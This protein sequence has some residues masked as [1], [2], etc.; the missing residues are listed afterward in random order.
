MHHAQSPT[1]RFEAALRVQV[2]RDA[3]GT[4]DEGV[5]AMVR[6]IDAVEAV[7]AIELR[8]MV[9]RLNDV[10]VDATVD[11][12]M[13]LDPGDEDPRSAVAAGLADGFG[14]DT[15]EHCTVRRIADDSGTP[16]L[17]YG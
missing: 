12:R 8:G 2:P 4:L 5:A 10:A 7:E 11:G 3:G 9:P 6:R 17:E 15:V 1:L 13:R 16:A 14:I